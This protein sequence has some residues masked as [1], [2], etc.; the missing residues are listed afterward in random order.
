M[1][2]ED[3][4]YIKRVAEAEYGA[5][6]ADFTKVREICKA[7]LESMSKKLLSVCEKHNYI[8]SGDTCPRCGE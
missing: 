7:E 2:H 1:K 5:T 8:H 3:V 6:Y 4:M